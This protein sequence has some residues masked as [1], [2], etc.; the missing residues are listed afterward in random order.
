MTSFREPKNIAPILLALT[1]AGPPACFATI[2]SAQTTD[3]QTTIEYEGSRIRVNLSGRLRHI[4]EEVAAASCS[5]NA[6]LDAPIAISRLVSSRAEFD[7]IFTSLSHGN[8]RLGIPSRENAFRIKKGLTELLKIWASTSVTTMKMLTARETISLSTVVAQNTKRQEGVTQRLSEEFIAEYVNPSELFAADALTVSI[9]GRQ[10]KLIRQMERQTCG[11]LASDL[12]YGDQPSLNETMQLF[13]RSLSAL[14]SGLQ[15]AGVIV[16]PN[17]TITRQ[18]LQI[19]ELWHAQKTTSLVQLENTNDTQKTWIEARNNFDILFDASERLVSLY[20]LAA[21]GK[22]DAFK[23]AVSSFASDEL[24][25]WS[26]SND[27]LAT[28]AKNASHESLTRAGG[29]L[30]IRI[31]QTKGLV[32][33]SATITA[34]GKI[35]ATS[36]SAIANMNEMISA[37]DV[38]FNGANLSFVSDAIWDKERQVYYSQVLLPIT[39]DGAIQGALVVEIN[40]VPFL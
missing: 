40:L 28:V 19:A 13:E 23:L 10:L 7:N 11:L 8:K 37:S 33:A 2:T 9:V 26:Q 38:I 34:E 15:N 29:F 35:L 12:N 36:K 14:Q 39:V 20:L 25:S 21:P 17:E 5:L 6:G 1:L 22:D 27:I 30:D 3:V 4:T 24:I 18:L 16:P 32:L 31:S